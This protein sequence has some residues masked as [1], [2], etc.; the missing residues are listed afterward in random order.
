MTWRARAFG[1]AI[2]MAMLAAVALASGA[3]WW[4]SVLGG[5]W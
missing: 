2:T 1:L 4:D 3:D 5:G